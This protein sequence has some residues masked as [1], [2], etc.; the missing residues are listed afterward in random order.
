MKDILQDPESA[1]GGKIVFLSLSYMLI[2][3]WRV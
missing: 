1:L 3:S 2:L